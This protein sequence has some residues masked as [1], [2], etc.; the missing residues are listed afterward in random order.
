MSRTSPRVL[1][2]CSELDRGAPVLFASW[3]CVRDCA[4]GTGAELLPPGLLQGLGLLRSDS[5]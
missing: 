3:Q 1:K 4:A 2:L 5:A